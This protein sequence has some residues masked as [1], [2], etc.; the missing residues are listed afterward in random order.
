[1]MAGWPDV[2]IGMIILAAFV[3]GVIIAATNAKDNDSDR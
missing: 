1:M 2:V 3:A